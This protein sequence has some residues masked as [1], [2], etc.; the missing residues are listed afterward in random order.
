MARF[1]ENPQHSEAVTTAEG[2]RQSALA[3][4]NGDQALVRLAEIVFYRACLAS[5]RATGA[6]PGPYLNALRDLK[7][8]P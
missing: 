8:S 3:A 6:Y 7:A 4:A 1:P 2:A 5:A